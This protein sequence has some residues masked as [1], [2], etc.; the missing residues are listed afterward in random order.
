MSLTKLFFA[1][2]DKTGKPDGNQ[3][4]RRQ[5]D[6]NREENQFLNIAQALERLFEI[7]QLGEQPGLFST[8]SGAVG[9]FA[10]ILGSGKRFKTGNQREQLRRRIL[11]GSNKAVHIRVHLAVNFFERAFQLFEHNFL[12]FFGKGDSRSEAGMTLLCLLFIEQ[13]HA[14]EE[15]SHVG[16]E[17][18]ARNATAFDFF[19][20]RL[21]DNAA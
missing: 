14:T 17:R 2:F 3:D 10:Q 15:G 20:V 12:P 21:Q 6:S 16:L 19:A 9:F 5:H 11:D 1:L 8:R 4:A 7:F 18:I 13:V